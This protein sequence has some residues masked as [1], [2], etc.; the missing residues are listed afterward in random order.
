M[1]QLA[2]G[3]RDRVPGFG[4][5]MS[6]P[7]ACKGRFY[8]TDYV[9]NIEKTTDGDRIFRQWGADTDRRNGYQT[10]A[11]PY[12]V[13]VPGAAIVIRRDEERKLT[14]YEMAI[15]RQELALFDPAKGMCRF[16]FLVCNNEGLGELNWSEAVGVFD[17][18]RNLGSFAPPW[19]QRLPCQT[20]FGIAP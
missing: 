13:P 17:Y 6:D 3:F 20:P 10:E 11:P 7:Y 18:W 14:V 19:M 2:F 12:M 4:R 8:D 16:R 1:L 9:Y 5:Q 15:P